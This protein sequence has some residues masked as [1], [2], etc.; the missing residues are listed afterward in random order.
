M[1]RHQTR[2]ELRARQDAI[3]QQGG[4]L[5]LLVGENGWLS[6]QVAQAKASQSLTTQQLRE[7]L[8]L[9]N[10]KRW[11]AEQTNLARRLA[12]GPPEPAQLSPAEFLTA[13][14]AEMT[15]AMKR[16]LPGQIGRAS[17]RERV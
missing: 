4:Q 12:T 7:L 10:E 13:L 1:L 11:L 5:S 14:T 6:N 17:C 8:R 16:I 2:L 3:E 9:R 15:E